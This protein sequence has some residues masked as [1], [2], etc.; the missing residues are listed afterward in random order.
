MQWLRLSDHL[1]HRRHRHI[2]VRAS[3]ALKRALRCSDRLIGYAQPRIPESYKHAP[4]SR[5]SLLGLSTKR[6]C[7]PLEGSFGKPLAEAAAAVGWIITHGPCGAVLTSSVVKRDAYTA[8][9]PPHDVAVPLAAIG[10]HNEHK[11]FWKPQRAL[12]LDAC[13][14]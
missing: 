4:D 2:A 13:A 10:F 7:A 5:S 11:L 8:V 14:S 9:P 3:R 6:R 12:R 1:Q